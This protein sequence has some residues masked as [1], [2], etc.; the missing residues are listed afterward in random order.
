[1][2]KW[3]KKM[4]QIMAF[5]LTLILVGTN[6]NMRTQAAETAA[7]GEAAFTEVATEADLHAA[8]KNGE[9]VKLTADIALV[10]YIYITTDSLILD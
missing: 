4:K 9:N 1:M 6:G 2:K 7:D 8:I 10:E 3:Q 5:V